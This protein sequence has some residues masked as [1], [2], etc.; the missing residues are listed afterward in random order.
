MIG[1]L[2][3]TE[4]TYNS[5]TG[6]YHPHLHVLLFVKSS[7]FTGNANNYIS[8]EEWTELWKKSAKLNYVPVVD[9][10]AVKAKKENKS[11][12]KAILETAKYPTK[13]IEVLGRSE[14]EK[15][16]ITDDLMQGLYRKRQ[17]SFGGLFKEIRKELQLTDVEN[18]DLIHVDEQEK[19]S[20]QGEE[21]IA[22]WN[23]EKENYYLK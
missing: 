18:G 10:R 4:V 21:I 6:E 9:I 20:T 19:E 5:E 3:S 22:I 12:K 8:Q 15:L 13:P 14:E 16:Q 1:F 23:W 11:L 17:I 7:Y 2:R